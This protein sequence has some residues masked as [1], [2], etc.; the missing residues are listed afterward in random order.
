MKKSILI[1]QSLAFILLLNAC[2]DDEETKEKPIDV[3]KKHKW[4]LFEALDDYTEPGEADRRWTRDYLDTCIRDNYFIFS[5]DGTIKEYTTIPC[6]MY[7]NVPYYWDKVANWDIK[8]SSTLHLVRSNL[9]YYN[10]LMWKLSEDGKTIEISGLEYYTTPTAVSYR[11]V[12]LD[13]E[14]FTFAFDRVSEPVPN[15][16]Y[17]YTT[18]Y[19]FRTTVTP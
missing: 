2:K 18:S 7:D 8:S 19:K 12:R 11:V 14:E 3:L 6:S 5:E 15:V 1:L 13:N 4:F 10:K 17:P 9:G 16:Q